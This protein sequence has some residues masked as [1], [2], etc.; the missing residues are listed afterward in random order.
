MSGAER[1]SVSAALLRRYVGG[2]EP[3]G[4]SPEIFA[5]IKLAVSDA[6]VCHLGRAYLARHES[7]VEPDYRLWGEL[8][9]PDLNE[10][11]LGLGFGQ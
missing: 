9:D 1:D 11:A 3:D 7:T 8:A 6:E 10:I 4:L 5:A 2:M